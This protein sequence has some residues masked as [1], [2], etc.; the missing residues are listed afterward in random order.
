MEAKVEKKTKY[1]LIKP[2][3]L[4]EAK[5]KMRFISSPANFREVKASQDEIYLIACS[6]ERS[7]CRAKMKRSFI[8]CEWT[9]W[10]C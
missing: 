4:V 3:L 1:S 8:A 6:S 7:E 9:K 10:A 5:V 2:I